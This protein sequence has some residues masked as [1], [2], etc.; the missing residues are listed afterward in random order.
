[1]EDEITEGK[2]FGTFEKYDEF[3]SLQQALLA[4]D[5]A[6][7]PDKDEDLRESDL[8]RKLSNIVSCPVCS[9]LVLPFTPCLQSS[10]NTRSNLTFWIHFWSGWLFRLLTA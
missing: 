1:M 10:M 2:L 8:L 6:V 4:V 5:L 7:E 9:Y 3:S